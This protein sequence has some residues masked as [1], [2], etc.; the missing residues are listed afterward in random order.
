[1][2]NIISALHGVYRNISVSI[3][4]PT[5]FNIQ[6]FHV[7]QEQYQYCYQMAL[8]FL[9]RSPVGIERQADRQTNDSIDSGIQEK[10]S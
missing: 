6:C 10:L 2:K 4:W 5:Q 9:E 8:A 3:M 7:L 1:M